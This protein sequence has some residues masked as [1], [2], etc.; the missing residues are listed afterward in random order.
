MIYHHVVKNTTNIS[1]FLVLQNNCLVQCLC[2]Y[3]ESYTDSKHLLPVCE[4]VR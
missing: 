4:Y 1:N 2:C 3:S